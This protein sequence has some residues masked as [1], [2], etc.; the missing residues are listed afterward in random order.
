M[1]RFWDVVEDD[2][3]LVLRRN[4]MGKRGLDVNA[5]HRL[6]IEVGDIEQSEVGHILLAKVNGEC[7]TWRHPRTQIIH[8]SICMQRMGAVGR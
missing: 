7:P 6:V 5:R 2:M 4:E 3:Y 1:E 8:G